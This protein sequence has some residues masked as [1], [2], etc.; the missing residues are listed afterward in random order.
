VFLTEPVDLALHAQRHSSETKILILRSPLFIRSETFKTIYGGHFRSWA[1]EHA[2]VY[3][4]SLMMALLHIGFR[5]QR[6]NSKKRS[7]SH[8]SLDPACK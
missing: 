8:A 7:L 5:Q 1:G 3:E 2:G 4:T 6:V